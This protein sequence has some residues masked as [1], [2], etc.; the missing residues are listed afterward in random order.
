MPDCGCMD[1]NCLGD[2]RVHKLQFDVANRFDSTIALHELSL[3]V[4]IYQLM[5]INNR[6][7]TPAMIKPID[8][9]R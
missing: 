3:S 4:I 9:A 2:P 6:E 8:F 7:P 1:C 5:S